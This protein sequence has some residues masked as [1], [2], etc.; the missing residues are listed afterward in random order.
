MRKKKEIV[1]KENFE[2]LLLASAQ[3]ALDYSE[4]KRELRSHFSSL[5]KEPSKYSKGKIKKARARLGMS[6]AVFAM[7]FGVSLSAVQHWEQGLRAM[8]SSARRLLDLIE[9]DPETILDL[10]LN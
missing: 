2:E 6:Q 4:G 7:V 5:I 8:P 10:M 1:N 9:K 3:E